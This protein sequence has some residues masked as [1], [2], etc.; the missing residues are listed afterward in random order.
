MPG[1]PDAE[2]PDQSWMQPDAPKQLPVAPYSEFNPPPLQTSSPERDA[3]L[4]KF[5]RSMIWALVWFII[6]IALLSYAFF[7]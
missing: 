6:G 3:A 1:I 4:W 7:G 5:R 2:L